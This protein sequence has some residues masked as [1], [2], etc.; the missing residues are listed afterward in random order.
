MPF[1][2]IAEHPVMGNR[3]GEALTRPPMVMLRGLNSRF[4]SD[5]RGETMAYKS[6]CLSASVTK[7]A[8]LTFPSMK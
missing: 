7:N 3:R 2:G 1:E 4:R 5:A 6:L 8:I